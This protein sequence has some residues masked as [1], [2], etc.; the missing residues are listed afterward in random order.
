MNRCPG[1]V[2]VPTQSGQLGRLKDYIL[3][4]QVRKRQREAL[5]QMVTKIL[6]I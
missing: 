4:Y 1:E 2:E 3:L 6:I 5:I